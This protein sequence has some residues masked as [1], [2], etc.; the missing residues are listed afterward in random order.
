MVFWQREAGAAM[1]PLIPQRNVRYRQTG[2]IVSR[3]TH[4]R[5]DLIFSS[6]FYRFNQLPDSP[7]YKRRWPKR[8]MGEPTTGKLGQPLVKPGIG[9][10]GLCRP[11]RRSGDAAFDQ[12]QRDIRKI[13]FTENLD[14]RRYTAAI[15]P[16]FMMQINNHFD[17]IVPVRH[18]LL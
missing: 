12:P 13:C 7:F 5:R 15:R 8:M 10:R 9:I 1:I 11:Y 2:F 16:Q 4:I 3:L 18:V 17:L 6:D 14:Q